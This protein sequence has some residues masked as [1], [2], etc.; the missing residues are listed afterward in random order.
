M[1]G[2]RLK[3]FEFKLGSPETGVV[4]SVQSTS[5][6][7]YENRVIKQKAIEKTW[8]IFKEIMR[9][10]VKDKN[11]IVKKPLELSDSFVRNSC[12]KGSDVAIYITANVYAGT[13]SGVCKTD[14]I[15]IPYW[16]L[17]DD[18]MDELQFELNK[19]L[20]EMIP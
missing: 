12:K 17:I 20:R 6:E 5:P 7:I 10:P 8:E 2:M 1:I 13:Y 14:E 15:Y 11:V 3:Y 4:L 18:Y 9:L 19:I 16:K